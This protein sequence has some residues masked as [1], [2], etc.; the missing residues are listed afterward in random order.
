[1]AR[2]TWGGS[3]PVQAPRLK[4]LQVDSKFLVEVPTLA[5][6]GKRV[7]VSAR[8]GELDETPLARSPI[9]SVVWQLRFEN[10][11]A[12][13]APQTVLRLQELLGGPTEFGLMEL[14][15]LQLSM[16]AAG[17]M[18][19]DQI[20]PVSGS[21]GGGWRLPALDGSWQVTVESTSL[22]VETTRYGTWEIGFQP[23][24][25]RVIQALAQ[26]G[27]PVIETRLGLRFINVIVG[28]VVG[29]PPMSET[30]E[31]AGLVA[32]WMLGPLTEERLHDSVEASQGRAALSF[33]HAKAV[34]NHGIV[35][36]ETREL[37]Y[38]VDIDIFRE[39]GRALQTGEVLTVSDELH[40][41]ALGLFQA[42]LTPAALKAMGSSAEDRGR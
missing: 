21:A 42:S 7:V 40:T 3:R 16:Q 28:S 23:R 13:V 31:L 14:P 10:H 20:K 4:S 25:Q 22:A 24:L 17:P 36:T 30:S 32:A 27:A 9:V 29:K 1:M 19:G 33:Q 12:L 18:P 2:M 41:E 37:G 38:L 11:P 15:R 6:Y 26:V 34:L 8:F 35:T 5:G 39:G